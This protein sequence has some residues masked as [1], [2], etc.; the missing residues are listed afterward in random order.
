MRSAVLQTVLSI[1]LIGVLCMPILVPAVHTALEDHEHTSCDVSEGIHQHDHETD[2]SLCDYL[3]GLQSFH[4]D[5]EEEHVLVHALS[6]SVISPRETFS[7]GQL[8]SNL[9]RGPPSIS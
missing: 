6:L 3:I 5:D 4:K 9:V 8:C 2:C 1:F 7:K